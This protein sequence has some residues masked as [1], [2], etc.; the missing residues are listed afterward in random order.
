MNQKVKKIIKIVVNVFLW[1]FLVLALL[2]TIFAFSA[3]A[4]NAG[5]PKFGDTCFLTVSSDSMNGPEGFKKGDLI[6]CRVLSDEEKKNLQEGDVVS[7]FTD[8]AGDGIDGKV[9]NTHRIIERRVSESGVVT[10]VTQ[11]DNREVSFVPDAP[12]GVGDIEAVWTGKRIGGIGSAIAFLRSNTG[13]LVCVVIPLGAF[14][15][16][17]LVVMVLTI[18][19]VRNKDK[20]QIT[21]EE[22]ELIKQ[23]AV[24]EY[25]ARQREENA[26]AQEQKSISESA[27]VSSHSNETEN[28]T[29]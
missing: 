9:L 25:L 27:E 13:F 26:R 15:V 10:Y 21:K 18:N 20:K 1:I 17:E 24:E 5:Y 2:M 3:Q 22:E 12:I 4:S 6:I 14:F 29:E 28:P 11:G 23:R 16:Y 19:R 8:L 7:Y